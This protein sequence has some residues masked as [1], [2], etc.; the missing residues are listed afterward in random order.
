MA[1]GTAS[2]RRGPPV[3]LFEGSSG[4]ADR[5]RKSRYA[6]RPPACWSAGPARQPGGARDGRPPS[7]AE[8][9]TGAAALRF[10]KQPWLPLAGPWSQF[11]APSSGVRGVFRHSVRQSLYRACA[12]W[13][14]W[15]LQNPEVAR[16]SSTCPWGG[17]AETCPRWACHVLDR[18]GS[19]KASHMKGLRE[20]AGDSERS[21]SWVLPPYSSLPPNCGTLP[22]RR[23]VT[24]LAKPFVRARSVAV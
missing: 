11:P 15:L 21:S 7:G 18:R 3:R 14:V 6:A 24:I 16:A 23:I 8:R 5:W 20:V 17:R 10:S 22:A 4:E 19:A 12:P 9:R 13:S 2:G 1:V